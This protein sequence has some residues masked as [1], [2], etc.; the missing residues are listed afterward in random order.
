MPAVGA[1]EPRR[2]PTGTGPVPRLREVPASARAAPSAGVRLARIVGRV[3][4]HIARRAAA[5]R[6]GW[7]RLRARGRV[8][9]APRP[10]RLHL[11]SGKAPLPGWV[12]LDLSGPCDAR[13]DLRFA[14]PA[15][16]ASAA[17]V[18]SE[19]VIEHLGFDD[20]RALFRECRR[21]LAADGVLRL[22]T[23]DLAA[24]VEAYRS[25]RWREQD[26]VSWPGHEHVDTAARMLN[27]G[28]REWGH[29]Y[30]YDF[31][32]LARRLREAGFADVRRCALGA[33]GVEGLAGLETRLDSTL[34][35][36]AS[37][38]V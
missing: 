1:P 5:I 37:G 16:D 21:V 15:D 19:H 33:S 17:L 14:L 35:V 10:L 34:V 30:L 31:D 28:L 3:P 32:E 22:A 18:Y 36:E 4:A 24:V 29:L 23:P 7:W 38:R 6:A 8:R 13:C 25:G 27:V 9:A 2:D 12:N 20:A 11:G 26:W